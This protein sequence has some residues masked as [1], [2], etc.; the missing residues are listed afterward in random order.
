MIS[1]RLFAPIL[2]ERLCTSSG[3]TVRISIR[4]GM[5]EMSPLY[6]RRETK[7]LSHCPTAKGKTHIC[8]HTSRNITVPF[9]WV[10]SYFSM[11]V[12]TQPFHEAIWRAR[13]AIARASWPRHT[14]N[15]R[16]KGILIPVQLSSDLVPQYTSQVLMSSNQGN[17]STW[18]NLLFITWLYKALLWKHQKQP[19]GWE[20]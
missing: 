11:S 12:W 8:H 16:L 4:K 18:A 2:R 15:I 3:R 7:L 6:L 17:C 19:I 13:S 20:Y 9:K 10:K 1:V 14:K 5:E